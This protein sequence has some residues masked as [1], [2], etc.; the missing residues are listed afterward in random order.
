MAFDSSIAL[1]TL[2]GD[3]FKRVICAL[4]MATSLP[5]PMAIPMSASAKAGAS[6]IPSPIMATLRPCCCKA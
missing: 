2:V 6:L 1:T 5:L 3:E 4:S